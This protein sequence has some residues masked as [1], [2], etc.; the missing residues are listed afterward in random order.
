RPTLSLVDQCGGAGRNALAEIQRYPNEFDIVSASGLDTESTRH[1][2]GQLWVW[3]AA[4]RSPDAELPREKLPLIHEAALAA[5]DAGD[6]I[7]D[8]IIADPLHCHFDPGVLLCKG[9][10]T[11]PCLAAAQVDTVRRIY[12][13][14]TNPR[15]HE[16]LF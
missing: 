14:V 11:A 3:Q 13:P 2:M 10:E 15:T 8:G 9:S 4:H 12:G 1:S 5:C 6:G 16:K 7:K